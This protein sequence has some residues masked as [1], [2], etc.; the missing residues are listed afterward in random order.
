VLIARAPMRLSLAGGGTDLPAF[1]AEYG[2]MVVSMAIDKYVYVF[3]S[4]NGSDSLHIS[5]SDF[6]TFF[7]HA[8][9]GEVAEEGK[10]RYARA[11]VREF[12]IRT[13]YSLFMASE[14]PPGT[15]LGSSSALAV[16][17][18]K[19]LSALRDQV[20][21]KGVVA[22][23]AA[24]IE[25]ERLQMPIGKQ[26]HYAAAFGGLNA[27]HFRP[28]GV[29]VEPLEVSARTRRWLGESLLIFF[30]EQ[31]H[32][33]REILAEQ[34]R[35]SRDED[36]GTI[37]ALKEIH[38]HADEARR[39]LLEDRPEDLGP[40]LHRTWL[41]KQRIAPGISNPRIDQ[42]YQLAREAGAAGGKIAGAGGGGF[43]LLLCPPGTQADVT[44]AMDSLGLS[45][46]DFHT[47]YSGARVLVNNGTE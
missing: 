10:L 47:D 2:G 24:L 6:S 36:P 45:R 14:M 3:I 37:R 31:S 11:F 16:A 21:D 8:G 38:G 40:I 13:G 1:Y 5:S 18:T 15:G 23:R 33:S 42:A 39:A 9:D 19:A 35:R 12:G 29:T 44:Q 41:E 27:I 20:P 28:D 32:D 25:I 17:L 26:D 22:E 46:A 30:T 4:T 43:L 7:R 34:R